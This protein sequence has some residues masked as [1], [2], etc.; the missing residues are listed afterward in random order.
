MRT[1]ETYRENW[2]KNTACAAVPFFQRSGKAAKERAFFPGSVKH[3][4]P[5]GKSL[6]QLK[7]SYLVS[8]NFMGINVEV[9]TKMRAKLQAVQA[10]LQL[11]YDALPAPKP[12]TL[13][14]FAGLTS[15][16]GWR[17][18]S[19]TSSHASGSAVD[20]NYQ[21]QPYIVTR[22]TQGGHTILGGEASGPVL[23]RQPAVDVYDRASQFVTSANAD[24]N[25]RRPGE[26]TSSVYQRFKATSD[27]LATYLGL[28]FKN[29]YSVV[30]RPPV[31]NIESATEADLLAA[32][33]LSERKEETTATA[34]ITAFISGTTWQSAHPGYTQTAKELYF[35]MLRDYE[36]VRI[37]MVRG[38][39]SD[40]PGNTR[41]PAKGF[42]HMPEHFVVAMTTI[43]GFRW[44]AAD[45]GA[46]ASGDVHH[47]DMGYR[48]HG[49]FVPDSTP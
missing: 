42:L 13:K 19:G 38:N 40:S 14:E 20:V 26:T 15:I 9:N 32:I 18:N 41:N 35:R 25:I 11:K 39:P 24:V 5:A 46:K 45:F 3:R 31:T 44:G 33:P 23:K 28:A 7:P 1:K 10:D 48:N 27:A 37:P 21:N 2:P 29:T 6:I 34:D 47:F 43:G 17:A 16:R 4:I 12:P 22:S 36:H 8:H 30:T 49:G